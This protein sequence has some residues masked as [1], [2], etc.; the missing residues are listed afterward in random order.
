MGDYFTNVLQSI[1]SIWIGMNVT[2]KHLFIPSVTL[3]YPEEKWKMPERA[4]NQLFNNI[5]DC[6]GCNQCARTCPVD[7]ITVETQKAKP[8]EDLGSTSKGTKRRLKILRYDIDMSLCCYC[9]LC[10]YVC[11]PQS[12]V[13]TP[14]YESSVYD[15]TELI[16]RFA[17]PWDY[18]EKSEPGKEDKKAQAAVAT[19]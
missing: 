19:A 2:L 1:F 6:I 9:G 15:R 10:T 12:L 16:Y 4:R 7:C 13:M 17:R 14:Q 18:Q 8:G 5:D 11:T 3:Q